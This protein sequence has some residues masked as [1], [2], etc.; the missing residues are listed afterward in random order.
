MNNVKEK[1][2]ATRRT[3]NDGVEVGHVNKVGVATK[4]FS[5]SSSS[6][7]GGVV[8]DVDEVSAVSAVANCFLFNPHAPYRLSPQTYNCFDPFHIKS[9]DHKTKCAKQ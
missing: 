2:A 6:S 5:S 8:D 1:P 7:V 3:G 9:S 4:V